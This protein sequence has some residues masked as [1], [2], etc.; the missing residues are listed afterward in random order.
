MIARSLF[1]QL[2]L[3]LESAPIV[4]IVGPRR[5][6]KTTLATEILTQW[7]EK[8]V[9]Y[10]DLELPSDLAKL[11]DPEGY[12]KRFHNT[13]VI[14]DEAQT[15][16]DIFPLLRSLVDLRR[17]SEE[18]AAH[19]LLLGS[20]SQKLMTAAAESLA[21]RIR[22]LELM[23][24]SLI[25]ISKTDSTPET[26]DQLWFRGGY[27]ESYLAADEHDSWQWRRDYIRSVVERDIHLLVGNIH[28][29]TMLRF[30]L[31]LSH[32][33]GQRINLSGFGKGLELS[34]T[35]VRN[36]LDVF[37]GLHLLRR[38]APWS[39]NTRKRIVKSPKIY[40]R[41][42]GI[43]HQLLNISEF[44]DL[45]GHPVI[46]YSW[47]GFVIENILSV[48]SSQ[49]IYSYYRTTVQTEIDLILEGPGRAVWAIEVK[50]G[51]APRLPN[52]FHDA[53][54]DIQATRKFVIYRGEDVYPMSNG[55]TAMP[56]IHFLR[57]LEERS[58][59]KLT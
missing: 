20:A 40:L 7:K 1:H 15:K 39:G 27:P 25:E 3:A 33:H 47:E 43:L 19:F 21:G 13:L 54:Q 11:D 46:G 41:D 34:H 28:A 30:W 53:C 26:Q 37:T 29:N 6:G 35:T 9:V 48:I 57:L 42:S 2:T 38:L 17:R 49:W 23:P 16:L 31:M 58:S 10:L 12:L 24:L 52:G 45:W 8:K 4:A 22:Y 5:V 32:Y 55:T 56:L 44:E 14:I 59:R 50:S 51:V 18:K 36:Y